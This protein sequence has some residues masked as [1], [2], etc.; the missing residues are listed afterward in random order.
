MQSVNLRLSECYDSASPKR[1]PP[2][3]LA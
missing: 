1:G 2:T 3:S